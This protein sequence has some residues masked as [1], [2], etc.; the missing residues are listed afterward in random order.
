VNPKV[1][2]QVPLPDYDDVVAAMARAGLPQTPAEAHGLALGLALAGIGD[3]AA[4]WQ[5]E[6]Y[7]DLDPDDV[8]AGECR[9]ML[10]RVYVAVHDAPAGALH[11]PLLPAGIGVGGD[12]LGAVRD[13]CQGFLYGFGLGGQGVDR[14]LGDAAAEWLRDI[15]EI[16]RVDTDDAEDSEENRAALIE[17]EEYLRVGL[18]LLQDDMQTS[19]AEDEPE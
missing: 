14:A 3:A 19:K 4:A 8:L 18:S 2:G 12:R 10:D 16:S 1:V 15:A 11:A 13:W 17:V 6:L 5:R 7:A 9:R